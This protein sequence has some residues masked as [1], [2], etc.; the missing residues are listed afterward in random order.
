M[1]FGRKTGGSVALV[2][3]WSFNAVGISRRRVRETYMYMFTVHDH[4]P[5]TTTCTSSLC[6]PVLRSHI[7][8]SESVVLKEVVKVLLEIFSA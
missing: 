7:K 3:V 2:V 1:L 8:I 5:I 6:L 4:K